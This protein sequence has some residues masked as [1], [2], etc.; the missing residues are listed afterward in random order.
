MSNPTDLPK[1]WTISTLKKEY[2]NFPRAWIQMM[3]FFAE[4]YERYKAHAYGVGY[5]IFIMRDA[6]ADEI[7]NQIGSDKTVILKSDSPFI[8]TLLSVTAYLRISLAV[9][10][11]LGSSD[12][13]SDDPYRAMLLR[14]AS[15]PWQE[16]WRLKQ[17]IGKRTISQ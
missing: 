12:T 7:L 3:I 4:A 6:T 2:R 11:R 14:K 9:A 10:V 1:V 8:I 15:R 17:S 5:L 16:L 13:G